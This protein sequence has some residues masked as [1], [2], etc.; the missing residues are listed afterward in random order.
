VLPQ[1]Q[2][3]SQPAIA[4]TSDE[5]NTVSEDTAEVSLEERLKGN[6]SMASDTTPIQPATSQPSASSFASMLTQGLHSSDE[7]L[8]NTVL[9]K[10]HSTDVLRS[11]V[12][13]IPNKL[14]LPLINMVVEKLDPK[15]TGSASH[16]HG[17]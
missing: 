15:Q 3:K 6:K 16:Q 17:G 10:Q 4:V 2:R 11:T 13:R 8:I 9:F 14:A 12:Q 7:Y 1:L 5:G